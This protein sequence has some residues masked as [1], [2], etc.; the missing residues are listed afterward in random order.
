MSFPHRARRVLVPLALVGAV[1]G[2]PLSASAAPAPDGDTEIAPVIRIVPD[3]DA[4][5]L[6]VHDYELTAGFGAS[7]GLWSDG[8]TGLDFAAPTGTTI[9]AVGSGTITEV[10]Y[11]G[12]YGNKTVLRLDDGTEIWFCH[13]DTQDVAVGDRVEAGDPIGTV[14][15]TGN[16]TGE[17]LHL[18]I[19]PYGGDPVD[20][21]AELMERGLN[22]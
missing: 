19:R 20:P 6:P 22:P 10:A 15:A 1:A 21:Y 9:R 4:W 17:H 8:H 7:S 16:V 14:G 18:E 3:P 13:Q 11:D 2:S 12:A 5:V